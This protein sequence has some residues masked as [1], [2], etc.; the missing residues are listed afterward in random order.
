M[1]AIY[2]DI[3]NSYLRFIAMPLNRCGKSRWYS[4]MFDLLNDIKLPNFILE[5]NVRPVPLSSHVLA[6]CYIKDQL[7]TPS[8]AASKYPEYLI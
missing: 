6:Y 3:N 1:Y 8:E 4:T 5:L 7:L 2:E